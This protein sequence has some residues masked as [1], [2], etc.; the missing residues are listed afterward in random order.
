M[1][2]KKIL[3]PECFDKRR[4]V[5]KDIS[6]E[7]N[8]HILQSC[9]KKYRMTFYYLGGNDLKMAFQAMRYFAIKVIKI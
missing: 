2:Q 3:H 9:S 4:T 5:L 6:I 8:Q 1:I 7:I